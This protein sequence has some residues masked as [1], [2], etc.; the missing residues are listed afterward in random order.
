MQAVAT[1]DSL[2]AAQTLWHAGRHPAAASDGEPTGHAALDQLLPQRGW[3]RRAL[4]E[5]LLPADG[6]GELALLMP[7]LARLSREGGTLALIARRYDATGTRGYVYA[8]QTVWLSDRENQPTSA[9][10][11]RVNASAGAPVSFIAVPI[12]AQFRMGV[13]RD[14]D[15]VFDQDEI[16][17]ASNPADASSLPTSFCRADFDASGTLDGADLS[18]FTSAHS[19]NNPRAN[20][21]RS[22]G[23]N[24]LP[25]IT[26]S[27]LSQYQAAHAAGCAM[28][29][30]EIVGNRFA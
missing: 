13:D 29:G 27:D 7:T 6:I 24:G 15:G 19:A 20:W 23:A 21:D 8:T 18:A 2:L 30:E 25:T 28:A 14:A 10:T 12:T 22:F 17:A 1:L 5:L 3:P 26:A 16:D 4:T 9:D 11:L